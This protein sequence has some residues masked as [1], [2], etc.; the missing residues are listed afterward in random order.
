MRYRNSTLIAMLLVA[1]GALAACE[2]TANIAPDAPAV[3]THDAAHA[4]ALATDLDEG[5]VR[6][7]AHEGHPD[8]G[9][10]WRFQLPDEVIAQDRRI[11]SGW[12]TFALDNDSGA[13]HFILLLR[14]PDE[15]S[16]ITMEEW[17]NQVTVPFQEIM[18]FIIDPTKVPAS[19]LAEWYAEV[20]SSGGPGFTGAWTS[21]EATVHLEPGTYFLDCYV[22]DDNGQFH[23]YLGMLER[24]EVTE[25]A[26]DASQPEPTMRVSV[27]S[28]D[29]IQFDRPVTA[30]QHTVEVVF[31]DQA[32]YD[33]LLGHDLHLVR[34]GPG[35]NVAELGEWMN[36]M[37]PHGLVAPAPASLIGGVQTILTPDMLAGSAP[38]I[39]YL[40]ADLEPGRY[41]WVSEVPDPHTQNMLKVFNVPNRGW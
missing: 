20:E 23:S 22:K 5:I 12:T 24:I 18:D 16:E 35:D 21:S 25:E 17:R 19:E 26:N 2:R 1:F 36:W 13:E 9:P 39:G 34:M 32:F 33:H 3:S 14:V 40:S 11:P 8:G 41:A 7:G 10:G 15:L 4:V 31:E 6:I 38:A 30:G 29:G 37:A 27:S 28:T